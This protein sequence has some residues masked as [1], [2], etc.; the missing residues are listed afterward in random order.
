VRRRVTPHT[1]RPFLWT[2]LLAAALLALAACTSA[3]EDPAN[4]PVDDPHLIGHVHG[5]GSD[6]A[7]GTLYAAGHY[8]VFRIDPNG[9]PTRIADRWQDTMAFTVTGPGTFLGSGHPDM[10]E[11][12]PSQLGLIESTDAGESWHALSLQGEADFH[13]LDVIDDR[14][15][16]FDATSG[17]VLTTTDRRSWA[18]VATGQFLDLAALAPDSIVVTTPSGLVQVLGLDG[19]TTPLAGAPPLVWIDTTPG[20][21]LLGVTASGEL[22]VATGI[23]SRWDAAGR[24]PGTPAALD[25]NDEAW[26][27]A[28]DQGIYRSTDRGANWTSI[29]GKQ[30]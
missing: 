7:D 3:E 6:P 13:T 17:R 8:G 10:R 1:P 16:G 28:T 26:H 4:G 14:I 18:T 29:V 21:Q 15:Y 24:V 2:L 12:L 20:G 30:E 23:G 22:F 5:L 9:S 19:T 11:D 25:A 27:V